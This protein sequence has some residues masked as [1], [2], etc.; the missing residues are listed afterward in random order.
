MENCLKG[1]AQGEDLRTVLHPL[2]QYGIKLN[3]SKC[4]LFKLEVRYLEC[5]PSAGGSK[6]D[7]ADTIAVRALKENNHALLG[8]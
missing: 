7:P 1:K 6:M 4:E 8:S 2:R 3:P 5:I